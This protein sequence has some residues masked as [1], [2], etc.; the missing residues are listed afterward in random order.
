M[1]THHAGGQASPCSNANAVARRAGGDAELREHVL[2]VPSHRVLADHEL[3]GDVAVRLAGRD[4][5]EDLGLAGGEPAGQRRPRARAQQRRVD[6]DVGRGAQSPKRREARRAA[7]AR[8]PVLVAARAERAGAAATR[9]RAVSY[10]Q[11]QPL[12]SRGGVAEPLSASRPRSLRRAR[13]IPAAVVATRAVAGRVASP[14]QR[15]RQR[16]RRPRAPRRGR[17][18][19]PPPRPAPRAAGPAAAAGARPRAPVAARRARRVHPPLGGAQNASPGC[20][21]LPSSA[22]VANASSASVEVRRCAAGPRRAARRPAPRARARP[23]SS[24]SVARARFGLGLRPGAAQ[25]ATSRAVHRGTSPGT[26]ASGGR[27]RTRRC[28]AS[29]HSPARRTSLQ[30]QARVRSARSR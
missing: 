4:E 14:S 6:L 26:G 17:P 15:A 3:D 11:P 30:L 5:P 9:A 2:Q 1:R 10:G 8:A 13:P 22:R 24:S 27:R 19:R 23:R 16:R 21:S 28:A 25:P 18:P 20:G 12:P 7:R 29:L